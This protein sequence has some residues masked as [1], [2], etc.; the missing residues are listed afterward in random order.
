[1]SN[2]PGNQLPPRL[3]AMIVGAL[4]IGLLANIAADIFV[5]SYSGYPTTL[6]LCG[7]VGGALGVDRWIRN[8]RGGGDR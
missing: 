8:Q 7:L 5:D 3:A 6:L 4:T 1:M 2:Y